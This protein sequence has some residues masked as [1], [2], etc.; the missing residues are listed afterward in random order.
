MR[1]QT[2]LKLDALTTIQ[3]FSCLHGVKISR[4]PFRLTKQFRQL[5]AD[6]RLN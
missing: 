1:E 5:A 6:D 2:M 4:F 3:Q